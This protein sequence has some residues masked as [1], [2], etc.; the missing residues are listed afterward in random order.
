MREF[1]VC[2]II[3]DNE[4]KKPGKTYIF[5]GI[6]CQ[7][8]RLLLP[9]ANAILDSNAHAPKMLRPPLIVRNIYAT[10]LH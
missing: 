9:N 8:K 6:L 4:R 10:A 2:D 5:D 1:D 7:H 3:F